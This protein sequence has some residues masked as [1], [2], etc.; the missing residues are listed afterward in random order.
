MIDF[1]IAREFIVGEIRTHTNYLTEGYAHPEQYEEKAQRGA[2][3]DVYAL[4]ATLYHTLT[5]QVP[6]PAQFRGYAPLPPP[7]QF[8]SRI[9]KR[10]NDAILKGMELDT[11]KRSQTVQD[12]LNLLIRFNSH[13]F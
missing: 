1:G 6:I 3:T 11:K 13:F 8:N 4:A 12:W 5:N 9:S 2:Y 7:Q 10:V